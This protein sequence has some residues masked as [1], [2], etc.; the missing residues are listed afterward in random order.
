MQATQRREAEENPVAVFGSG[1]FY[2]MRFSSRHH[3]HC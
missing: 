3:R 2:V 1:I